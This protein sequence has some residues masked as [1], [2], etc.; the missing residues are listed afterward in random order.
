M[1]Y[2]SDHTGAAITDSNSYQNALSEL[3]ELSERPTRV[4]VINYD[5][6]GRLT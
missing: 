6:S 2:C 4:H 5:L 1:Y 3:S